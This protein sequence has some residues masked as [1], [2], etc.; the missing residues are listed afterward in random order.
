[1]TI[2]FAGLVIFL[3]IVGG[4]LV[5]SYNHIKESEQLCEKSSANVRV[6]LKQRFDEVPRL[7]NICKGYMKHEKEVLESLARIRSN[8]E[9]QDSSGGQIIDSREL[10]AMDELNS[11]LTIS[12]EQVD[13]LA[14][15]HPE[16]KAS[17]QLL[18]LQKRLSHLEDSIA[19][20]REYYNEA[21]S[22]LNSRLDSFPDNLLSSLLGISK[23]DYLQFQDL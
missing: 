22:R 18:E 20:R 13:A 12:L 5:L 4:Y 17:D 11:E 3:L 16:L 10:K 1:M 7:V 9:E 19:D 15:N 2:V 8:F 14:E 23:V 6:L 21:A